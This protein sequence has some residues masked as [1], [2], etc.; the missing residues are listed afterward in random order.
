MTVLEPWGE[1]TKPRLIV[2]KTLLHAY[3]HVRVPELLGDLGLIQ[4]AT[5][6]PA[7]VRYCFTASAEASMEHG[8]GSVQLES[9]KGLEAV[10][11]APSR[12]ALV[13]MCLTL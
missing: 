8:V 9:V 1:I 10:M 12:A 2:R 11:R 3:V 6:R 5:L 4:D 13:R 7:F